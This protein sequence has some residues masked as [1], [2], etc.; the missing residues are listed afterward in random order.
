MVEVKAQFITGKDR[1]AI[2]KTICRISHAL[3]KEVKVGDEIFIEGSPYVV[4]A[5]RF[6]IIKKEECAKLLGKELHVHTPIDLM[7]R[8]WVEEEQGA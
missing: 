6:N 7:E 2:D 5:K 1:K 4:T 8:Y 3:F